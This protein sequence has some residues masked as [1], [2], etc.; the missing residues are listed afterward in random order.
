[1]TFHIYRDVAGLW[2]W[3]LLSKD[4]RKIAISAEGYLQRED[5]VSSI[6]GVV[7]TNQETPVY[8]D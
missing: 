3:Y 1:M 7:Q 8:E 4:H 2:R 6:R 5:C